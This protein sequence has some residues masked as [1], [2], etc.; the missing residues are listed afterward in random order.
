MNTYVERH[1]V[2]TYVTLMFFV[3]PVIIGF[4]VDTFGLSSKEVFLLYHVSV[5]AIDH[6][7]FVADILELE[8]KCI[9]FHLKHIGE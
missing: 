5:R 1:L 4:F 2:D 8:N 7:K 9:S 6:N 3:T